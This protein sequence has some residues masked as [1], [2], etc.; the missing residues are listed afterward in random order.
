MD[1]PFYP[2]T[3][4]QEALRF[5]FVSVGKREIKKAIL[6]SATNIPNLYS[7]TLSDIRDDNSLDIHATSNNG[8]MP[9]ILATASQTIYHFFSHYP[10]SI[11]GFT[12]STPSRTRLYQIAIARELDQALD[13]FKIWGIR[14]DNSRPEPFQ[15]NSSYKSF[16]ITLKMS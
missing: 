6:Y 3:F 8:D 13:R 15:R 16:F 4:Q 11:I 2:F 14:A 10:G 12:G 1:Q 5:E 9:K 7:L